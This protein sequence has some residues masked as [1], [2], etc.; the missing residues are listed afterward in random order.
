[1]VYIYST[2]TFT[3]KINQMKDMQVNNAIHGCCGVDLFCWD[4][5]TYFCREIRIDW[6]ILPSPNNLRS[7]Y[8]ISYMEY[9]PTF[10]WHL[11]QMYRGT[12]STRGA[13]DNFWKEVFT[14]L[15]FPESFNYHKTVKPTTMIFVGLQK[16]EFPW[17][18][19]NSHETSNKPTLDHTRVDLRDFLLELG[20]L[21]QICEIFWKK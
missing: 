5:I 1:M 21:I 13:H 14:N 16:R 17:W 3:I 15:W 12:Y 4:K 6:T 11:R 10:G 2:T 19:L 9:V 7:M 18:S 20:C 8:G